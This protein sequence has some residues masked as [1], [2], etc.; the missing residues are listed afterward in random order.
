MRIDGRRVL[1]AVLGR[2]PGDRL[3]AHERRV[4]RQHED[5]VLGVEVVED[6]E[7]DAHRVAGAALHALLDE[8]DR[9]L[10]DELV[11]QGLRDPFGRVPDHDDD[12]LERQLRER[13]DDVQHHRPAAQRVQDLGRP[14]THPRAFPGGED[15]CAQGSVLAHA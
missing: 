4:A 6:G 14:R 8:L 9:H 7:R 2:E 13:V 12:A 1:D 3:R 5:V 15:D 11:V 10:G